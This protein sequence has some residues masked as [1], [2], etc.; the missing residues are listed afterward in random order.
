MPCVRT[1]CTL[2]MSG[3]PGGSFLAYTVVP[4]NALVTTRRTC[5]GSCV[6][7]AAAELLLKFCVSCG[8]LGSESDSA[9]T[10]LA[11]HVSCGR[12]AS[13]A[14]NRMQKI[15]QRSH[16][17]RA[18]PVPSRYLQHVFAVPP[19]TCPY[20]GVRVCTSVAR[21]RCVEGTTHVRRTHGYILPAQSIYSALITTV[22]PAVVHLT[23]VIV[24]L[25]MVSEEINRYFFIGW[26]KRAGQLRWLPCG[27]T[28]PW[29]RVLITGH[30]LL[31][32]PFISHFSCWQKHFLLLPYFGLHTF[33]WSWWA[34]C[35]PPRLF[36]A[37][38]LRF[39]S[40]LL[41]ELTITL[42]IISFK[43]IN[44]PVDTR[45]NS[46]VIMTSK[47]RRDVVLTS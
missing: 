7:G 36:G 39:G 19:A 45:R 5:Y 4:S 2:H 10:V 21:R 1:A 20:G 43:T 24:K 16:V 18:G 3:K 6:S 12:R 44:F 35:F 32:A 38:T 27:A 33:G 15:P 29:L 42:G 22:I 26:T 37:L 28:S 31:S 46:N 9:A 47:R 25:G 11:T 14:P 17:Q 8:W 41:A 23:G 40:H 13:D 34:Y 30:V